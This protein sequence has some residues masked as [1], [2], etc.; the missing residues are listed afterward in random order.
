LGRFIIRSL[1]ETWQQLFVTVAL[2]MVFNIIYAQLAYEFF[3]SAMTYGPLCKT[4]ASCLLMY[5]D[6]NLKAGQGVFGVAEANWIDMSLNM[7][8]LY[9]IFYIIL[10]LKLI[11][12]IFSGTIIDKFS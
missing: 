11:F 10:S 5:S 6:Q 4:Q 1:K 7:Q 12:E 3:T 8:V 9:E 2:L